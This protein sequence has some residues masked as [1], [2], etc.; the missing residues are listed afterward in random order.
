MGNVCFF[1]INTIFLSIWSLAVKE[2]I[3]CIL[4]MYEWKTIHRNSW[5]FLLEVPSFQYPGMFSFQVEILMW[6]KDPEKK[7]NIFY[8]I[9]SI[10]GNMYTSRNRVIWSTKRK[11][12]SSGGKPNQTKLASSL[13]Q[14]T[15][16]GFGIDVDKAP[17]AYFDPAA[18]PLL[19]NITYCSSFKGLCGEMRGR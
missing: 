18:F 12:C 14:S 1:R 17:E 7:D 13:G 2:G 15:L 3:F 16:R 8:K 6:Y 4:A 19:S 5:N 10:R 9:H 11:P